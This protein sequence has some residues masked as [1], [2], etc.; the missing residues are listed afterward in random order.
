MSSALFMNGVFEET[1]KEILT[2]QSKAPSG[3][4]FLQPYSDRKIKQLA[5]MQPT[6]DKPVELYLSVTDSLQSVTFRAKIFGWQDKREIGTAELAELN[7]RIQATQPS[8][9]EIYRTVRNDQPCVN[10]I[11]VAQLERLPEPI[12]VSQFIK[13]KDN[14]PLRPRNRAGGW[15]YVY[16][17]QQ[18]E[19]PVSR[20]TGIANIIE[21]EKTLEREV[22]KSLEDSV[23]ERKSRLD[24]APKIPQEIQV[25]A[26]AFRRNPDVI[27]EVLLRAAGKC[28]RCKAN[29]PFLR[30]SDGSPYVEVHHKV[31]LSDGGE[32]TVENAVALCPNC[33]RE[34]HFGSQSKRD[35]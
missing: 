26:R 4:F 3:T 25:I 21:I 35:F 5:D 7:K 30:A 29:G 14:K 20:H 6:P 10:L 27:A 1:L 8:E 18:P 16:V 34:M 15:S 28:E 24:F 17:Y 33:H 12:R 31:H 13:V 9:K 11:H 19:W 23:V 2:A 22:K 32:D